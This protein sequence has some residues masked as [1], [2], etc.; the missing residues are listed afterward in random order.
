MA[1]NSFAPDFMSRAEGENP[2]SY[3]GEE[4]TSSIEQSNSEDTNKEET[5]ENSWGGD[6][7]FVDDTNTSS[8]FLSSDESDDAAAEETVDEQKA[9][10]V[11]EETKVIVDEQEAQGGKADDAF[12]EEEIEEVLEEET[13]PERMTL[14]SAAE[15]DATALLQDVKISKVG[16]DGMKTELKCDGT[17]VVSLSDTLRVDYVFADPII[18]FPKG[19]SFN[20]DDIDGIV[21]VAGE[22][23]E[24]PS[25]PVSLK[26]TKSDPIVVKN[27]DVVLGTV[28][29]ANDGKVT[30]TISEDFNE[31]TE[32]H[33]ADA[34][35][36][37]ALDGDSFADE[38]KEKYRLSFGDK[39]SFDIGISE[40]MPK[41]PTVTKEASK[42]DD[43]GFITWTVVVKNAENPIEYAEGYTISD[44]FS[45]GQ[46]YA[47][48]FKAADGSEITPTVDDNTISW[49]VVNNTPGAELK[50]TYRTK[51]DFVAVTKDAV[52][53][54]GETR[55][56]SKELK[57]NVSVKAK[58]D[59]YGDLDISTSATQ[60]ANKDV[61]S[62]TT[63]S[64]TPVDN[65]GKSTWTVNI[66]NNGFSLKDVVLHD[67]ITADKGVK[68]TVS[69]VKVVDSK[70][71]EVTF[72][73]DE[74]NGE[75]L[76][77]FDQM[78]GDANYTV[79]YDTQIEDYAKYIRQNH[80]VPSNKAWITYNY[81]ANG[82]GVYDNGIVGP[83]VNKPFTG[84]KLE[85]KAAIDKAGKGIDPVNHT[86]TWEVTV[87]KN[88]EELL[89]SK[90]TDKL[91]K[92]HEFVGIKDVKLDDSE[93][94]LD[95]LTVEH[96][97]S[98]GRKTVTIDFGDSL[99]GKKASFKIVTRLD[100]S[101]NSVWAANKTFEYENEVTLISANNEP[102][103]D[104]CK[105]KYT[106]NVLVKSAGKY[107]YNTHV[108][109][110]K[111]TI[112]K[113]NM[114]MNNVEIKDAL[115][116]KLE[117]VEG[118]ARITSGTASLTVDNA[119]GNLTFKL[120]NINAQVVLEFSAKVKDGEHFAGNGQFKIGNTAALTSSEYNNPVISKTETSITNKLIEKKQ[121]QDKNNPEI[122]Y[123]EIPL[124]Q[125]RQKLYVGDVSEVTIK[126][127]LGAS[128]VLDETTIKLYVAS[129]DKDGNLSAA[130]EI[131]VV[132]KR[133]DES[134]AKTL[135]EIV[136]P[137]EY[138][139]QAYI[140]KY[141]AKMLK[142]QAEDF[143]NSVEISGYGTAGNSSATASFS[144]KEF[145]NVNF[146][147]YTYIVTELSDKN[148]DDKKLEGGK[149]QILDP[150]Q[151]NKV[152]A[153]GVSDSKG[154]VLFVGKLV[155]NHD[156]IL[157]ETEAPEGYVIP[158]DL[159][160]GIEV[161]TTEKGLIKAR[162]NIVIVKN[163]STDFDDSDNGNSGSSGSG[164]TYDPGTG[165]TD[166]PGRSTSGDS[167]N[168][169][170]DDSGNGNTAEKNTGNIT[171]PTDNSSNGS[172]SEDSSQEDKGKSKKSSEKDK[173]NKKN[174]SK[175]SD[176]NGSSSGKNGDSNDS[177]SESGNNDNSSTDSSSNDVRLSDVSANGDGTLKITEINPSGMDLPEVL[178]AENEELSDIHV[179]GDSTKNRWIPLVSALALLVIIGI[180]TLIGKKKRKK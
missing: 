100:D 172:T 39:K 144:H 165:F 168:S 59:T 140:L 106:S 73:K 96:G 127:T 120:G 67:K 174:G 98:D 17:D 159:K 48:E 123:Y 27:G 47:G 15:V 77:K 22:T 145:S 170:S 63:K 38:S 9:D 137:K 64:G 20:K 80:S 74:A 163:S 118:S 29:I 178:G 116:E 32:A 160:E 125:A 3:A 130:D 111:L 90:V 179:T 45:D 169:S 16:N 85:S 7:E 114:V 26:I 139:G 156:Y 161:R 154:E 34:S 136:I 110:Y 81:D 89:S 23:Y 11:S 91:P 124:N 24:L 13:A 12:K 152:V 70:E 76:V 84:E 105:Q 33:Q 153:E 104:K 62:W 21:V 93:V 58:N 42:V 2:A 129:V 121:N 112:N 55:T 158:K 146:G 108:I 135:I 82:D 151:D 86:M 72:S 65:T 95:S 133:I 78:S 57:N 150:A 66:T 14:N 138:D 115:D 113:N 30:L 147:K 46:L 35:F 6:V 31:P 149:F 44:S 148:D 41:A 4:D 166:D 117:Y 171:N 131:S 102:V 49:K 97:E 40:H 68:I 157:K 109:P 50:Y 71:N 56:V 176:G 19:M 36:D 128:F 175:N 25:I 88:K 28:V 51:A 162:E 119:A 143:S 134:G 142:M 103:T 141:S 83:G 167:E 69:N 99:S 52:I 8:L 61:K 173:K 177:G 53:A 107:D 87:N 155:E 43:D 54:E 126:D 10:P 92:G 5:E 164:S 122:V 75:L 180:A 101:Q 18:I 37:L 94:S 1:F 60:S 79:T 132:T